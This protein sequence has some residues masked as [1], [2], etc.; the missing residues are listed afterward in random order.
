MF[1]QDFVLLELHKRFAN[2]TAFVFCPP[3]DEIE[4]E[5]DDGSFRRLHSNRISGGQ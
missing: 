4:S 1:S 5:S 3:E 2:K